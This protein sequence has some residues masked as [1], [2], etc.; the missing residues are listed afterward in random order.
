[1]VREWKRKER[2]ALFWYSRVWRNNIC[3]IWG[4]IRSLWGEGLLE[5][6][7]DLWN[8]VDFITNLFYVIWLA[9]RI[10]SYYITWRDERTG[11]RTWYPREE[12]DSFEPM[13]LAEGAFA[14][15]MIFR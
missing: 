4:E 11:K 5:Y 15:G 13:L 3:L 1:M 12:W 6:I 9:L 2:G 10:A 7:A 8:I 14:A